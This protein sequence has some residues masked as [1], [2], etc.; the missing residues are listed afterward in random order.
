MEIQILW[1]YPRRPLQKGSAMVFCCLLVKQNL[2]LD[3]QILKF[4]NLWPQMTKRRG[5]AK[6]N[7][8]H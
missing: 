7:F 1:R 5:S 8:L 3:F 4:M 6:K 2:E